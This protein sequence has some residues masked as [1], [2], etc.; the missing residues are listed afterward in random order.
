[1]PRINLLPWRAERLKEQ[2]KAFGITAGIVVAVG[3]LVVFWAMTVVD[4]MISHQNA[5]NQYLQSE[6]QVLDRRIAEI[7]ELE[8]RKASLLGRM[9]VIEQL[10]ASRPEIVHLFD[11][12]VST[13]PDGVHLT[14]LEQRGANLELK[15][16]AQ[17]S[18][19][20]SAYMRAIENSPHLAIGRLDVIQ[21]VVRDRDRAQE[22]TLQARQ[23]SRAA[24]PP[25]PAAQPAGAARRGR[26]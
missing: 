7:R 2:Q 21:S 22:F 17:S 14:S 25:E 18:A 9:N 5:R 1:M 23:V 6:I 4:G 15:G 12:L 16:V 11:E 8:Q 24:P 20:V 10:Q 19:R 26:R 3:A 13:M